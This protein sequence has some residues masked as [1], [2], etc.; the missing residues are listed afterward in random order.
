MTTL[1]S[2]NP[3]LSRSPSTSSPLSALVRSRSKRASWAHSSR[4]SAVSSSPSDYLGITSS[5]QGTPSGSPELRDL[6]RRR[7]NRTNVV[8]A[9]DASLD[10]ETNV[11]IPRRRSL[12]ET[13][14]R[15]RVTLV[16][17]PLESPITEEAMTSRS[18]LTMTHQPKI[19]N[20][21]GL[22][23]K[24]T[25]TR[26]NSLEA[27]INVEPEDQ[28]A[29]AKA[30]E[31]LALYPPPSRLPRQSRYP[32]L[33]TSTIS[34]LALPEPTTRALYALVTNAFTPA[35]L[36]AARSIQRFIQDNP[37]TPLPLF[38]ITKEIAEIYGEY[39][40]CLIGKCGLERISYKIAR[41]TSTYHVTDEELERDQSR[42]RIDVLCGHIRDRHFEQM[43]FKC[44]QCP[45][46]YINQGELDRHSQTHPVGE[47]ACPVCEDTFVDEAVLQQHQL[48]KHAKKTITSKLRR[49][50]VRTVP[51][52]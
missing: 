7:S 50:L 31:L 13:L 41:L 34:T 4:T 29:L 28:E 49:L 36:P 45:A 11:Y 47:F 22:S 32:T 48:A 6:L 19:M 33:R 52:K 18:T 26:R 23:L 14:W 30:L 35:Q 44:S 42:K 15:P 40:W 17:R 16:E 1:L 43:P 46:S 51:R 21:D 5:Q 37:D 10:N 38:L 9:E 12:T 8:N 20:D 25:L 24:E 27:E 39:G 2:N 3:S